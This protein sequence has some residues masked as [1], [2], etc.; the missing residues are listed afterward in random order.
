MKCEK[1]PD[2]GQATEKQPVWGLTAGR[3]LLGGSNV[4][5]KATALAFGK[6]LS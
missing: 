6:K 5:P 3:S 4:I 1:S 2:A